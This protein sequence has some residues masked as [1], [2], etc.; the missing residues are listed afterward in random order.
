M[1][2]VQ[3]GTSDISGGASRAAFRLHKGMIQAGHDCLSLVRYK[4][5][6]DDSV[7]CVSQ[8]LP[9]KEEEAG[10]F[11]SEAVQGHYINS[12]RTDISNTMFSLPCPGYDVSHL[13]VVKEADIINLHWVACFQSPLTLRRLFAL[14]KPVVW[15][16]HDQWAFTGGCHYS[17]GCDKFRNDCSSCPQLVEDPFGLPAAAL[18]DKVELFKDANLVIV[19]PS[20]WMAEC[21]RQSMLFKDLRVEV[22]PNS[23]ETDVFRPHRKDEAKESLGIAPDTVTIL[24]GGE[25]GNE[26]RKGFQKFI[27]AIRQCLEK[28][29]FQ[30]LVKGGK[31][32][33]IC[34]GRPSH[35][36]ETMGMPV[37]PLGYLDSDEKISKA[38]SGA[39]IFILPSLEDNLPNTMLES[40]SCGTPVVAFEIGGIPDVIETGVT[41]RLVPPGNKDRM[42][43]ELISLIKDPDRREAMGRNCRQLMVKEY[44]LEVQALRYEALYNELL[45]KTGMSSDSIEKKDRLDGSFRGPAGHV[46]PVDPAGA[47]GAC[48]M[49]IF[50]RVLLKALKELGF[51]LRN[52][53]NECETDSAARLDQIDRLK[54]LL[55]ESETDSAARLDQIDELKDLLKGS[56]ADRSNRLVQVNELTK[57]LK[58][59]ERDRAARLEVMERQK[60]QIK[61]V[62]GRLEVFEGLLPVRMARRL[63]IIKSKGFEKKP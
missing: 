22:I 49:S 13:P 15:T 52:S 18:K 10:L 12:H 48:F 17:A 26:K 40:M 45:G 16:L 61:S 51:D 30:A 29:E 63:G 58:E 23:L 3:I 47:A 42:A 62:E 32:M 27:S 11:F 50:D 55:K 46:K 59:S 53:L 54:D 34:F 28:T 57:L 9:G 60:A 4:D 25:D 1:K 8:R 2:I 31:V 43:E 37:L 56:E 39:D 41:G 33:A 20:R 5:S 44:S 38:Y 24:F 21:A 14:G 35:E 36:M 7:F 19:T 6:S